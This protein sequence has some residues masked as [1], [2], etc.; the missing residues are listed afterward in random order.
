MVLARV[1]TNLEDYPAAI[2]TYA[3]AITIRPDR[4]DLFIA[5]AGL[6]ERLLRFDEAISDYQRIY[7]LAYKDPQWMEKV[8]ETRARQ[9]KTKETVA[10]LRVA[11]IHGRPENAAN[12]FEAAR[13]LESW[14][15]L[16]EARTLAEQGIKAAG[17]DP[18]AQSRISPGLEN[19]L[20][21]HR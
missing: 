7:E 8:A 19:L 14:E 1:Q 15:M 3:K 9:G 16:S 4:T 11:L 20:S 5:R 18:P 17:G 2:D 12:Y 21:L 10:A 6:E 13:R